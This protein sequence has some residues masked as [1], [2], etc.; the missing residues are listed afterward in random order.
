MPRTTIK[1]KG[2]T[3]IELM[4]AV[5][6]SV[7]VLAAALSI[8]FTGTAS[9]ANGIGNTNSQNSAQMAVRAIAEKIEP[10]MYVS[11][12]PNGS[13]LTYELP[14]TNANGSY[15]VPLVWDGVTR[16]ITSSNNE[17]VFND[18]ASQEVLI[19]S[20]IYTDPLSPGGKSSYVVFTPTAG[21]TVKQV[22]V[23][24]ATQYHGYEGNITQ[25]RDRE[26]INLRNVPT[27]TA[28]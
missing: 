24:V 11:V 22:T 7:I 4:T 3:L 2:G 23:E 19:N 10:A 26:I 6:L 27:V 20:V 17:I 15:V 13:T 5:C 25:N 18:G 28:S 9:W 8:L 16:T 1:K 12:S 14:Q 21:S